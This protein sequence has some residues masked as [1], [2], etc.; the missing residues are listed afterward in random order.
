MEAFR[1]DDALIRRLLS[2]RRQDTHKGDYGR[3]FLLCG[4]TGFTGA[5]YFAAESAVRSGAGLVDL[6]V[7]QTVYQTV[8]VKLNEAMV[9]PVACSEE[10]V[11]S[12]SALPVLLERASRADAMLIGCGLGRGTGPE[13][14]VLSLLE[15]AGVPV[16]VDADGI[17]ALCAHKDR[18]AD[19]Q[20][21]IILTPHDGELSRLL[22]E[23]PVRDGEAR[24]A[25][26][27]RIARMLGVTLVMKGHRTVTADSAGRV[28]VNTT[29]NAGMARGGS[30]DVLAGIITALAAQGLSPF[31]AA[32]AGVYI[33]GLAGDMARSA[34]GE[35][36]MT[37][38]DMIRLLPQAFFR[39]RGV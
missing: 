14:V 34:Y 3:A 20:A 35:L 38:T 13:T 11:V 16:V 6:L 4:A 9:Y 36:G 27:V 19:I 24:T 8:A 22:G 30:G 2:P 18:I 37:P 26:A 33:H 1:A 25:A 7:P 17:N 32:A 5:A 21:E 15:N 31:D 29:G 10:G 12:Q 28:C 39:C 23:K